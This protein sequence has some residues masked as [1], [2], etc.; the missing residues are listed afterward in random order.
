MSQQFA[1]SAPWIVLLCAAVVF[2]VL[3]FVVAP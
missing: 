1:A 3:F 2:P